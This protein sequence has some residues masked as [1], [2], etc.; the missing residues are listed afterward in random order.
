LPDRSAI[1]PLSPRALCRRAGELLTDPLYRGSLLLMV[2]TAVLSGFGFLFWTLAA[3]AYPAATVGSFSGLT[4]GIGLVAAIA[5]LGLPNMVTRHL[6]STSSPRALM[7]V[8]LAAITALGGALSVLFLVGLGPYLPASLDLRAH[9]HML[10]LFA[11]LVLVTALSAAIDAA[12]IA[13]RAARAL[14]W[15]NLAGAVARVAGLLLLTSLRSSGLILAYSAGLIL[16]T[17]LTVPPL[18]VKLGGGA[19][20][21]D[22][23]A[24]FRE[25]MAG[26][27]R[28]YIATILG[29]LPG[30]VVVLEVIARLGAART[31]PFATASLV[32]GFLAVIP[33]TTSQVLF[34]EASRK[35][36]TM[37]GQLRKALRAIYAL[38]IP[39]I[40]IMVAG[41]PLIMGVFGASYAA[42]GSDCLRILALSSLFTGGTYLV[43]SMLIARDRTAAYLFMNGANA[44]LMLGC[45]GFLLRDGINGG[46][47]GWA[48]GQGTSLL[49]GL[50]VVAAGTTGRHRRP[51][52]SRA[53]VPAVIAGTAGAPGTAAAAPVAALGAAAS[54]N[55]PARGAAGWDTGAWRLAPDLS[56][57]RSTMP[58]MLAAKTGAQESLRAVSERMARA[59]A[60]PRPPQL[61]APPGEFVYCG[62][63]FPPLPPRTGRPGDRAWRRLPLLTVV[64][65]YSGWIVADMLPSRQ[66]ADVH[67]A[68]LRA[69]RQLG[70]APRYLMW[71]TGHAD[72][73]WIRFCLSVGSEAVPA[74]GRARRHLRDVHAYIDQAFLAGRGVSSL[75][76]F[77]AELQEWL[78]VDNRLVMS[79]QDQPPALLAPAD[80]AAMRPL[81]AA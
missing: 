13:F 77:R 31:A 6:T 74:D 71:A 42:Q 80:R 50:V 48:L 21:G 78:A 44:A 2:N 25:Y 57:A 26:N 28:N 18:L 49:L 38:L 69:L 75:E 40:V 8:V 70:G 45:V 3:R 73:E 62:I 36:V 23:L 37:G 5:G 34:A 58:M 56:A 22:A 68:C 61:I 20:L 72:K 16:A 27:V 33:S 32:A 24:L 76:R 59:A 4:S 19:H 12:L 29:M 1:G 41:A 55:G 54:G 79:G 51:A 64:S 60:V 43:D 15:A 17:V 30:S 10:A 63:W 14:L 7:A 81:N 11:V 47:A 39:G 35:G 65:A 67:A 53:S 66:P 9:G 52:G 46:A